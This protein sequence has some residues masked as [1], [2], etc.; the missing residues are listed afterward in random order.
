MIRGGEVKC[1]KRQELVM[2]WREWSMV[3]CND[4]GMYICV[5]VI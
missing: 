1:M 3:G 5:T 2:W 4:S